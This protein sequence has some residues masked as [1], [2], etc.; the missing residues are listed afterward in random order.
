[1]GGDSREDV[2]QPGLGIDAIH[3]GRYDAAA[4]KAVRHRLTEE[5]QA[6][7]DA[8]LQRTTNVLSVVYSHIYF[9]TY[10]NGLKDLG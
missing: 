2:C 4:L 10:S 8:I 6:K 5:L 3:F 7:I 9:P 1:M